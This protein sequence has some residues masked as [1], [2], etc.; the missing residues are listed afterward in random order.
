M[1]SDLDEGM[2]TIKGIFFRE[3][4]TDFNNGLFKIVTNGETQ[5]LR[6]VQSEWI[7]PN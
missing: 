4:H 1:L 2:E 5:Y 3:L 7:K 6:I